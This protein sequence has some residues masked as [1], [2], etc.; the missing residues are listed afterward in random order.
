MFVTSNDGMNGE[1][2]VPARK[3]F[4]KYSVSTKD[5]PMI[6]IFD[7]H[8]SHLTVSMLDLAED[9][10][11]TIVIL[12]PHCTHLMSVFFNHLWCITMLP[13]ALGFF[14]I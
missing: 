7:N 2:F 1:T 11:L 14:T 8:E 5:N 10:G 6:L 4:I 9:N 12:P 13:S 3:H